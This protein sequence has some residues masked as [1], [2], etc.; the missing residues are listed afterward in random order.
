MQQLR[1]F[2]H[3]SKSD[4]APLTAFYSPLAARLSPTAPRHSSTRRAG[5]RQSAVNGRN[6]G[7]RADFYDLVLFFT[8]GFPKFGASICRGYESETT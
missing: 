6:A 5:L 7:I 2:I 4:H 1:D 8:R 3:G